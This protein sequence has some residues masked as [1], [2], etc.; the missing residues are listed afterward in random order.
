LKL[1]SKKII[2][3]IIAC[4]VAVGAIGFALVYKGGL[5]KDVAGDSVAVAPKVILDT[6]QE[7]DNDNDG[8]PDW[9]ET[10]W[11]TDP[12]NPDT[13][14][15]GT[16]DGEEVGLGRNPAKKG[17][18]DELAAPARKVATTEAEKKALAEEEKNLT[19]TEKI[20]RKI[21]N[22]YSDYKQIGAL[23]TKEGIDS[24][25][26]SLSK[27]A[28]AEVQIKP[29]IYTSG[30]I[31]LK[32]NPSASDIA[33][34]GNAVGTIIKNNS[35]QKLENELVL[36][37]KAVED[38]DANLLK[39]LDQIISG[40]E[41]ILRDLTTIPVPSSAASV[42]IAIMNDMSKIL[43][44]IRGFRVVFTDP[45]YSF[46][47]VSAYLKDAPKMLES[48]KALQRYFQNQNISYERTDPGYILLIVGQ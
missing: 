41:A 32:Q 25:A 36:F 29:K 7:V 35:P 13:D 11:K 43:E 34:Y 31:K 28:L 46:A 9:E 1:P 33:S 10:L 27:Q 40:Y 22:S 44:D 4:I 37:K 2:P 39:S 48:Y 30:D 26:K 14:G 16:K 42:H 15:D 20:S 17:P 24:F 47:A 3:L 21:I 19:A 8:L 45:I 6:I 5:D 18:K 23:Q 12:R 38:Q